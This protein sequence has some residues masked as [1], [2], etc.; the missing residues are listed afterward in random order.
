MSNQEKHIIQSEYEIV[1]IFDLFS[2]KSVL[3]FGIKNLSKISNIGNISDPVGKPIQN[4]GN[5]SSILLMKN[6][7]YFR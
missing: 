1:I 3:N 5:H 2:I 4:Y 6:G 7:I